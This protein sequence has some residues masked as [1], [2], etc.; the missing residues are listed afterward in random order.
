MI[1]SIGRSSYIIRSQ[2]RVLPL[3]VPPD[4]PI[5]F[6]SVKISL[7]SMPCSLF[8]AVL[9]SLYRYLLFLSLLYRFLFYRENRSLFYAN[10]QTFFFQRENP[11]LFLIKFL[12]KTWFL[13]VS[14]LLFLCPLFSFSSWKPLSVS[15]WFCLIYA[16]L[17]PMLLSFL[18][19]WNFLSISSAKTLYF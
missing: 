14:S 15:Y 12:N 6:L 8:F 3:T 17:H 7:C 4:S 2:Q 18:F 13:N 10:S 11:S 1:L 16:P 5:F 9:F 19:T